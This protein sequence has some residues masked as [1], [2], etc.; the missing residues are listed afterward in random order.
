MSPS[1]RLAEIAAVSLLGALVAFCA[2]RPIWDIDIFWHVAVGRW[3]LEHLALPDRDLWSAADPDAPWQ[4][5]QWLYQALV[6]ALDQ[7]TGLRGVRVA[8]AVWVVATFGLAWR[9]LRRRG[10]SV[11]A[12]AAL[13]LLLLVVWH[14]RMRVRPHIINLTAWLLIAHLVDRPTFSLRAAPLVAVAFLLW[15][16]LHLGGAFIAVVVLAGLSVAT[17]ALARWRGPS[18]V[19]LRVHALA[20]A[21]LVGWVL[22][23][24][25]AGSL[26][27]AAGQHGG[28]VSSIPEWQSWLAVLSR[29]SDYAHPNMAITLAALPVAAA[30]FAIAAA[31]WLRSLRAGDDD[32][33][34][35]RPLGLLLAVPLLVMATLWIR[36]TWMAWPAGLLAASW[37]WRDGLPGAPRRWRLA[38]AGVAVALLAVTIHYATLA[39]YPSVSASLH[40]RADDVDSRH[41]P[42]EVTAL[43]ASSGVEGRVATPAAWGGYILYHAWPAL[44]VTVDGRMVAPPRVLQITEA[45][46]G[47]WSSPGGA[48]ALPPL[49]AALPADFLVMPHPA[50]R[51][52][53]TGEWAPV[54]S[55]PVADLYARQGPQLANWASRLLSAHEGR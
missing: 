5:F 2:L 37:L 17:L 35:T 40:A 26:E 11:V 34:V 9:L 43:L 38:A 12:T 41:F 19:D 33:R 6:A 42:V 21:A 44:R 27:Y 4:S 3:I 30:L 22:C 51:G 29:Y 20:L 39:Q 31:R 32:P 23:P 48:D 36:F 46:A 14:D 52:R 18:P 7:R 55:S 13:V 15:S 16:A 10:L 8:H 28:S 47:A 45:I 50:F 25:A 1:S 24:G 54:A 49:Y 53:D